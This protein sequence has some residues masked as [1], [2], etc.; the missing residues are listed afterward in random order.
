MKPCPSP[1]KASLPLQ[2]CIGAVVATWSLFLCSAHSALA[3]TSSS[4]HAEQTSS[5]ADAVEASKSRDLGSREIQVDSETDTFYR[6]RGYSLAWSGSKEAAARAF[7]VRRALENAGQQGLRSVD[8]LSSL[9][10]GPDDAPG[11]GQDAADFDVAMTRAI[12]RYALDVRMGRTDPTDVYKDVNLPPREF[13]AGSALAEAVQRNDLGAFLD[14]LPPPQTGYRE[15]IAALAHYRAIAEKGGWPSVTARSAIADKNGKP[16]ALALRLALED[17][18]LASLP[19]PDDGAIHDA[20]LRFQQR[21]GIEPNGKLNAETLKAL[22][23]PAAVRVEEI[24]ANMERWRWL[25]RT[26]EA[27]Y[28]LV[29]VPDQSLDFVDGQDSKLH[30]RIIIGKK[31][32]PTPIMKT[33]VEAVVV[34]PPWDIPDD[35]AAA[36]ILPK[37]QHDN[38]YLEKRNIVLVDAPDGD[39]H[40][41]TVDWKHMRAAD[42]HYQFQQEA[43]P[44]NALGQLMLDTPNTFGVYMH[45]TSNPKLFLSDTRE[46]SHGCVRVEKIGALA[47]LA[48]GADEIGLYSG[49]G[50]D[51]AANDIDPEVEIAIA[52]G[53]TEHLALTEPLAVYML[54][55]TAI[56]GPDGVAGFRPDRYDR[57]PPLLARLTENAPRTANDVPGSPVPTQ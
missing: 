26:F 55:W 47:S 7:A 21:N 56:G 28:I 32:T 17:P 9:G 5:L 50:D 1:R 35:I 34:N 41:L 30:S 3:K 39:P 4:V 49:E 6:M 51:A 42:L 22:N 13:G 44:E 12:I 33:E 27:R 43:G 38:D 15:L 52:S 53:G 2:I 31:A 48:L 20:L 14:G 19:A 57:D 10:S 18:D 40:G 29:N 36:E 25:P 46:V 37:L 45:G 23:V 16:A 8:Y 24:I 54:Y 11:A